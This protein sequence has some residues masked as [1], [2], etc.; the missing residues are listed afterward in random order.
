MS[1]QQVDNI[2]N[3][4]G[5]G[6]PNYPFGQKGNVGTA[7]TAGNIGELLTAVSAGGIS[8]SSGFNDATSVSLTPG[9]W[10]VTGLVEIN[11]TGT[12]VGW[13]AA[14]SLTTNSSDSALYFARV[15]AT[16]TAF[17]LNGLTSSV[18]P[19]RRVVVT[20]TTTVY[21]EAWLGSGS[22]TATANSN[23]RAT[24]VA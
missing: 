10:D 15:Q 1:T 22:A 14:I 20:V 21:L 16:G 11:P 19:T 4:A 12:V 2:T 6:S 24:R 13:G 3:A 8:L 17:T 18:A 7:P 9:V 23:I 5:T